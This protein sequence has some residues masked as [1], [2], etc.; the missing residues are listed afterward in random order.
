MTETFVE[1]YKQ[2]IKEGYARFGHIALFTL[3]FPLIS[4]SK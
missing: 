3:G 2:I 1:L 4:S